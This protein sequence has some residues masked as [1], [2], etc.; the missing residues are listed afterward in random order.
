MERFYQQ[1]IEEH[2]K[3]N[4][5]ML[6]LSGARQVGK[7]T[8]SKNMGASFEQLVY[9]NW[10]YQPHKELIW[11]GAE[12]ILALSE[13]GLAQNTLVCF[14]EIHKYHDW[15]IFLKGLFDVYGDQFS[16]LVTG[17]A[18]LNV[19]KKGG[20]SL[21]GRYFILRMSPLSVAELVGHREYAD[22]E[23][24]QP[25]ALDQEQWKKLLRFGGFP[26][27]YMKGEQAFHQKWSTLRREQVFYE[28]IRDLSQVRELSQL[29][30]LDFLLRQQAG[31]LTNYTSLSKKLGVSIDSIRNWL[32]LFESVYLCFP[33]LPWSANV[34]RSLL[35]QPKYYYQDWSEIDDLGAR[36]ENFFAV[37]LQKAVQYWQDR[38]LGEYSLYFLRNKE[39]KEVDFLIVKNKQPWILIEVKASKNQSLSP[40][41]KYFQDK[42][43]VPHAFQVVFDLEY[44]EQDCFKLTRPT[45]VPAQTLLSQLV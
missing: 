16:I 14:D 21:M 30:Q 15:K 36:Y 45:I 11:K 38:G 32:A 33:V 12:A 27:P 41:L 40:N 19:Y 18:R 39:G 24:L 7:T 34:S 43:N 37:H 4:R 2:F 23:L 28:D 5:Q 6:F 10:D 25:K 17:S 26:E 1:C 3:Q 20:D 35:K 31:Q 44:I 29:Q 13:I 22:T 9:L 8:V 42:L